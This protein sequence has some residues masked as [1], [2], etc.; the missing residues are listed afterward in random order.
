MYSTHLLFSK[1]PSENVELWRDIVYFYKF[2]YMHM[3][4]H[5]HTRGEFLVVIKQ[6]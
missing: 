6:T 1:Y 2:C 5:M 4:M 3:H